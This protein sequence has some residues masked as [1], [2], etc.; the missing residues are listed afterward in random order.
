MT[1][2]LINALTK[3]GDLRVSAWA[4]TLRLKGAINDIQEIGKQLGV[5]VVVQG[6]VRKEGGRVKITACLIDTAE[7]CYLW[8]EVYDRELKDIFAVQEEISRA[9]V[10]TL[11]V[12]LGDEDS[13]RLVKRYTENP[14]A[15]KLYLKGRYHWS[16]RSEVGLREGLE[17]FRRALE[18]D[19]NYTLAL[20]GLADSLSL[21]GNYGVLPSK[22]VREEAK[23]AALR[24]VAL[25]DS[26]SE[27][28]AS[29]GH[30]EATYE[31]NWTAAEQAFETAVRINPRYAT[32]HHWYAIT[33]LMPQRRLDEA[34]LEIEEAQRLDPV[35]VSI[36][37]D[38][39]VVLY[40]RREY[41]RS[42]QQARR[43]LEL[44]SN[45]DEGYWILGLNCEQLGE[46]EEAVAA[47]QKGRALAHTP[48]SIGA[49]GHAYAL[50]GRRAEAEE[51]LGELRAMQKQ[52]Y[53]SPFD[54]ALVHLGLGHTEVAREWLDQAYRLRC[55]ELVW[56]KVD[57]RWDRLRSDSRFMKI[58]DAL[59]LT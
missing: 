7:G 50:W 6:S 40:C 27:T 23:Q 14:Q 51:A 47:L 46:Y 3:V 35:S 42:K 45:F 39:G 58:V 28:H 20:A 30:V 9:I 4:S 21:L 32:A 18:V 59:G 2:E 5:G 49:L 12:Q 17:Y 22:S 54:S 41:E 53:V 43:T 34:L 56:L 37:R 15:Y 48:R 16:K 25:D 11:K 31:W 33:C 52:R 13:K 38:A 26:L 57:P 24:A 36:A 44:D 8:S 19:P 1:E 10:E 55:Y 29:L